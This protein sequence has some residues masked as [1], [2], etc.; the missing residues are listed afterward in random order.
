MPLAAD[1][2]PAAP[3]QAPAAQVQT[4][5]QTPTDAAAEAARQKLQAR[6][7]RTPTQSSTQTPVVGLYAVQMADGQVI[8]T[9]DSARYLLIGV[10]MDLD[11]GKMLYGMGGI[12]ALK[13]QTEV[14]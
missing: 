11:T 2:P 12:P 14:R 7:P 6:L 4:I 3:I 8:F 13:P 5:Q 10:M 1:M 9:D